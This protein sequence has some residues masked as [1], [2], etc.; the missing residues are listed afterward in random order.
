M[1]NLVERF[2]PYLKD[3]VFLE[4]LDLVRQNSKG[5]I[6]IVGGYVYRNLIAS[7]Y[8][9]EPYNFDID[10]IVEERSDHLKEVSGW[11]IETNNYGSQNYVRN[12]NKMSLI[13]IRKVLRVSGRV[14]PIIEKVIDGTPL[15]IQSI[16]YDMA[17]NKIIG[18]K[19]IKAISSKI[20]K[21]NNVEQADFYAR[22]KGKKIEEIIETK[23]RELNFPRIPQ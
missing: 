10:F 8:G 17:E 15:N 12:G 19:G 6:W 9:G 2:Q 16:A 1:E 4:V 3:P 23:I 18:E 21:I 7:L 11:W 14:D 13:D 20:I 22:R 5:K